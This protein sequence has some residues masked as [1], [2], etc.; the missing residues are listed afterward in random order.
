MLLFVALL[1]AIPTYGLSFL[2]VIGALALRAWTDR[3]VPERQPAPTPRAAEGSP[4]RSV[5]KPVAALPS[6]AK[7]ASGVERFKSDLLVALPSRGVPGPFVAEI[8]SAEETARL[9]LAS[10]RTAEEN[11]RDFYRQCF[12]AADFIVR[13]WNGLHPAEQRRFTD[14]YC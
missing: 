3:A 6:W 14:R 4:Q 7:D 2:P 9:C 11:G 10:A 12:A 13:R 8:F 1:L 5:A